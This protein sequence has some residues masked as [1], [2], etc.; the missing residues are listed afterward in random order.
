MTTDT[1]TYTLSYVS[2][3]Y[4]STPAEWLVGSYAEA[5]EIIRQQA[6]ELIAVGINCDLTEGSD[7][8]GA[9]VWRQGGEVVYRL[10][11][12]K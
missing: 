2:D 12:A 7:R 5:A 11:E 4:C 9:D 3:I 1:T 8:D 6:E 10:T